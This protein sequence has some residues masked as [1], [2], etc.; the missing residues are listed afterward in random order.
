MVDTSLYAAFIVA[1]YGL[2][3]TPGPDMMFI[4]AMGGK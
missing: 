2:S 3:L 4:L 1:A